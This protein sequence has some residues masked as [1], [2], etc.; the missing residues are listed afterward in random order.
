M[1]KLV[2][3]QVPVFTMSWF[4]LHFT[5]SH[6]EDFFHPEF[7][8]WVLIRMSLIIHISFSACSHS[9]IITKYPKKDALFTCSC[10]ISRRAAY[11]HSLEY[12]HLYTYNLYIYTADALVQALL[13][14]V[15]TLSTLP[16]ECPEHSHLP[17]EAKDPVIR[18]ELRAEREGL[19]ASLM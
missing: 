1:Q 5:P 14:N 19:S 2:R 4:D 11:T 10:L 13:E 17:A 9:K 18:L 3:K 16:T 8:L 7:S 12:T 6:P 15:F